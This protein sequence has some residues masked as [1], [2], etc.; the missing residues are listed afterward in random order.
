MKFPAKSVALRRIREL[1]PTEISL[2]DSP[3]NRRKFL[4]TKRAQMTPQEAAKQV[5]E[6]VTAVTPAM[7][8]RIDKAIT[9]VRKAEGDPEA[10][11][12]RSPGAQAALKAIGRI[13]APYA[14]ELTDRDIHLLLAELGM[15]P[16]PPPEGEDD[17][18]DE[19]ED[20]DNDAEADDDEE[21]SDDGED[22]VV[23]EIAKPDAVPQA[24]HDAALSDA[25]DAYKNALN[26]QNS[27]Q[28]ALDAAKQAYADALR[29]A[30][31][32]VSKAE[33]LSDEG[34]MPPKNKV[35]KRSSEDDLAASQREH[36]EAL[37]KERLSAM[38]SENKALLEK[39]QKLEAELNV[40]RESRLTREYA[41]KAAQYKA[42]GAE[43]EV[44]SVLKSCHGNP[45]QMAKMEAIF[46]SAAERLSTADRQG[47]DLFSE[48][49]TRREDDT[50]SPEQQIQAL[51]DQVV[52]KDAGKLTPAKAYQQVLS[53]PQGRKLYIKSQ[54][55]KGH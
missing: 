38:Q 17:P 36:L 53:T 21:Q 5:F 29:N 52:Q 24:V 22:D 42:L 9:L 28:D 1:D 34:H 10:S 3:A 55:G 6:R 25:T 54:Q 31:Y 18:G 46:K 15:A 37:V 7:R 4:I 51:V 48:I 35:A 40:E 45:E 27:E 43:G 32:T 16:P 50:S 47:G 11:N 14:D 26:A 12:E 8:K 19:E 2:V 41:Q 13:L 33:K 49:G 23:L 20:Q 39:S 30:G 44:A